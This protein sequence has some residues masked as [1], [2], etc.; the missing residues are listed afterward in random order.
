MFPPGAYGTPVAVAALEQQLLRCRRLLPCHDDGGC[1]FLALLRRC[2]EPVPSFL[3]GDR[4]LVRSVDREG[5]DDV[6]PKS[7]RISI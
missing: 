2:P 7:I 3:R 5:A 6:K 1:F 4:V